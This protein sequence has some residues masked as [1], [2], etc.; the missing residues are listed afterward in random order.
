MLSESDLGVSVRN[1]TAPVHTCHLYVF[2]NMWKFLLITATSTVQSRTQTANCSN[3]CFG[4]MVN[5]NC[6][7]LDVLAP[8]SEAIFK[9][10][11]F[12]YKK[13][14]LLVLRV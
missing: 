13:R 10:L 6:C 9:L 14:D 3:I 12:V 11:Y 7:N 2:R 5:P 8:H 1:Q 4:F